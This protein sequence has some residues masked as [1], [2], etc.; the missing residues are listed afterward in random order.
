MRKTIL[1]TNEIYHIF[2][3][4]ADKRIIFEDD[5]DLNRFLESLEKFNSVEPIGSLYEQSF[6]KIDSGQKKLVKIIAY[7]LNPNHFHLI[8]QQKSANG[9]SEFM[10][11]LG[12][13]YTWYFNNRHKRTGVL[14]QGKFKSVHIKSNEQLLHLSA[15]VNLNNKVHQ[16]GGRTAKLVRSS[17]KE[18]R[19]NIGSLCEKEVILGQFKN[20]TEYDYFIKNSLKNI[21]EKR[22]EREELEDLMIE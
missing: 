12:G 6:S 11:R 1:T 17:Y 8:L 14:F 13:G 7:C 21:L 16:L 5:G 4:G 22:I 18:Y 9:I 20:T 10:K 19:D 2:N 3:R 15:Y